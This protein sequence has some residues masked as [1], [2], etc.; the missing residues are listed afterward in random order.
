VHRRRFAFAAPFVTTFACRHEVPPPVEPAPRDPPPTDALLAEDVASP[1]ADAPVE[2]DRFADPSSWHVVYVPGRLP[3]LAHTIEC[4]PQ[5]FCNPPHPS[6]GRDRS[7]TTTT[8]D[9]IGPYQR[10]AMVRSRIVDTQMDP[11]WDA[12]FVDDHGAPLA[13]GGC[14]IVDVGIGGFDCITRRSPRALIDDATGEPYKLLVER[15]PP[16]PPSPPPPP[17]PPI[18]RALKL[19]MNGDRLLI[20]IGA[21]SESG[22][23]KDMQVALLVGDTDT[24]L[25]GGACQLIRV[26]KRVSICGVEL[27]RAQVGDNTRLR[28]TTWQRRP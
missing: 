26:S 28:V 4:P 6:L 13:D 11:A 16:S 18:V 14:G 24:L 23:D 19:E 8:P 22:L 12:H 7:S 3:P 2:G 10:G 20:T 25:P 17:P 27:T 21:G 5:S 1:A 15:P 9:S